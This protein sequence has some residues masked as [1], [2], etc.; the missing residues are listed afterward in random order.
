MDM[1]ATE[2]VLNGVSYIRK[3]QAGPQKE[4]SKQIVIL[5]RGWVLVGDFSQEGPNCTLSNAS[6]IRIWGTTKGLGELALEGPKSGTKLDPC[7]ACRFHEM[8]IIGRMD[9]KASLWR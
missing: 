6:V 4:S 7:G 1:S 2:V 3:D 8:N 9:T 5:Q